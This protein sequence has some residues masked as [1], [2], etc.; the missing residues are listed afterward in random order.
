MLKKL[1]LVLACGA[2]VQQGR[3]QVVYRD[4]SKLP[5]L[6]NVNTSDFPNVKTYNLISSWD[7]LSGSPAFRF[8][9]SADGTGLL[10]NADGTYTLLVNHEDNFAVSRVIL[11]ATFQPIKGEYLLNS[12]AGM[13]R[14]C[15]ST[16]ATPEEHGFGPVYLT[17]GESSAESMTH[18]V[19]PHGNAVTDST[20]AAITTLAG[21]GRWNA[22]NAVP[23]PKNAYPGQ[24]V[25]VIGDDDSGPN[26]GQVAMYV[27]VTGDLSNG[28]VYVLR[29]K[30]LN[31]I[32]NQVPMGSTVDV[33]FV[34][35]P[36]HKALTGGQINTYSDVTARSLKFGRVEDLDYRK[37]NAA[38]GREIYF[39]TTGTNY[40]GIDSVNKTIWGK[41]YRLVLDPANPLEGKLECILNGDDKSA[42]NPGAP[43]YQPDNI[44]VTED[45]VYVQED[46]NGY[47]MPWSLPYVHDARIYQYD[48]ET[49]TFKIFL[50]LDHHRSSADSVM[51]NRNTAGTA[52]ARSGTGAWEYGAMIDVSKETGVENAFVISLQP[53]SFRH[54]FFAGVDGGTGRLSENQGSLLISA[55]GVPRIKA[56]AP[57]AAGVTICAGSSA[58]LM[59]SGGS[60]FAAENGTTYKWYRAAN[61]GTALFTGNEFATAVLN[62]DTTF[63]VSSFVSGNESDVRTP[64]KVTVQPALSVNLGADHSACASEVID[65]GNAGSTYTWSTGAQTQSIRV[66]Q[67]GTYKVTVTNGTCS[68]SDSITVTINSLPAT[69]VIDVLNN[70]TLKSSYSSGNE[71]SRNGTPVSAATTYTVTAQGVYTL[72]HTDANNCVSAPA[73]IS[74]NTLDVEAAFELEGFRLFPNPNNGTFTLKYDGTATALTIQVVNMA[75][76]VVY[77]EKVSQ[78]NGHYENLIDLQAQAAGS[79]IV[80]II[81]DSAVVQKKIVKK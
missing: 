6:V 64:I 1:L 38:A 40:T 61:G 24:T 29:R 13:W 59:A 9:G 15:S 3:A 5:S 46:P 32:E 39:N 60:T 4:H 20:V 81:T 67:G 28:K 77:L 11:D 54:P 47:T 7:T 23:L 37:G 31:Q 76:Q 35:V 79:Y 19:N 66:T 72:T 44:C 50:E 78:F 16:M 22:E 14:L 74:F 42:G 30:D 43:L 57:V 80:N 36:D 26:G 70:L 63:Y 25:V 17:C 12:N 10:K 75:G 33:E 56:K 68:I 51:F 41:V 8:G 49:K 18:M 58:R 71:W 27:S 48:I 62:A 52:Y 21:F 55:T 45:Y 34:L 65:A 2:L 73:S 53:H 69:P